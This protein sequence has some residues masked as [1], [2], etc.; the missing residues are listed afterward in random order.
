M[1]HGESEKVQW[2]IE[3]PYGL[4]HWP[5]AGNR[6]RV[7]SA[8]TVG[9]FCMQTRTIQDLNN[10]WWYRLLKVLYCGCFLILA[11]L[12][13]LL[14]YSLH[15]TVLV[16]NWQVTCF[17]GN[18]S[19]FNEAQ[20]KNITV[21]PEWGTQNPDVDAQ[22]KQACG[23]T[24]TDVNDAKAE[25]N[26]KTAQMCAG[27]STYLCDTFSYSAATYGVSTIEIPIDN[28]WGAV[29][30]VALD[31]FILGLIFEIIRRAFYYVTLGTRRPK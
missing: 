20:Y 11:L 19:T 21:N 27:V 4:L 14:A 26:L 16:S 29:G 5:Y 17:Y 1:R 6:L 13:A 8:A 10:K 22:I 12:I 2:S 23:I 9:A 18:R 3:T 25:A 15:K 24:Q 31:I 30:R 7:A 28:T